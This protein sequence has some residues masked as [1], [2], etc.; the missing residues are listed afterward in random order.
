MIPVTCEGCGAPMHGSVCEYCGRD[1]GVNEKSTS[2]SSSQ[3][4]TVTE[5]ELHKMHRDPAFMNFFL[6]SQI[7]PKDA[8]TCLSV[9][10]EGVYK[11]KFI[12]LKE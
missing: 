7:A 9:G 10:A 1:Y 11:G 5:D 2:F 12:I 4:R 8:Q 6:L 3:I